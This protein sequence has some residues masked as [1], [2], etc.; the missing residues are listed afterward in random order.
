MNTNDR[1]PF[2]TDMDRH[3]C[4]YIPL[5]PVSFLTRAA[6]AFAQKVAVIDGARRFWV[7]S[8]PSRLPGQ[9][10]IF[11]SG[12]LLSEATHPTRRIFSPGEI[13][14]PKVAL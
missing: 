14:L 7:E 10:L 5:S 8:G 2:E 11:K 13:E 12:H 9:M 1:H 3:P 4:N 6:S